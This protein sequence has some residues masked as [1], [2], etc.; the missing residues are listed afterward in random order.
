MTR[1]WNERLSNYKHQQTPLDKTEQLL[2]KLPEP[3]NEHSFKY[4]T[5][6]LFKQKEYPPK[7]QNVCSITIRNHQVTIMLSNFKIPKAEEI[8]QPV[9]L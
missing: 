2:N 5:Q 7:E 1:S 8:A 6:E 3:N 4:T 9:G